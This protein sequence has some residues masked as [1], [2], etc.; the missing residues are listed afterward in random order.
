MRSPIFAVL[1]LLA[2][3]SSSRAQTLFFEDFENGAAQWTLDSVWHVESASDPCGQ[4]LAP[5][6]SGIQCLRMGSNTG[7]DCHFQNAG[8]PPFLFSAR[9]DTPIALVGNG[10]TAWL[11]YVNRA[12]TE[13]C[14]DSSGTPFDNSSRAISTDGGQTWHFLGF[15]CTGNRWHK[16][17]ANLTPYLGQQV[18][19]RFTFQ[20][21]DNMLNDG[22]G[23]L[24][25]DVS[26]RI[27]PGAPHCDAFIACP[28]HNYNESV[29]QPPLEDPVTINIGGCIHS[30]LR[31]A[32]LYGS[33][34]ASITQDDVVLHVDNMPIGSYAVF[35]QG[36]SLTQFHPLGEGLSCLGS[37]LLRLGIKA[38]SL[39]AS[40]YPSAANRPL[41]ASARS[42]ETVAYQVHFRDP[43]A[44]YCSP[45]SRN[46]S[47]AYTI[48]WQP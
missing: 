11:R 3:S 10:A 7:T 44:A 31:E 36:S 47:N 1:V 37:P 48:E 9:L 24:I 14:D 5:F 39:G 40:S 42:G 28:C 12:D 33:G 23:W 25:D 43:I 34:H 22:F 35:V 30:G 46:F 4:Q 32:E 20:S 13:G 16:G 19:I 41:S 38:T 27:E 26:V 6:P 45:K 17:R 21:G 15:D 18:L 29:G 2:C 8:V